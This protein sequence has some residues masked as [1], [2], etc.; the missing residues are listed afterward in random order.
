[1]AKAQDTTITTIDEAPKFIEPVVATELQANNDGDV[2]SGQ[3]VELTINQG[4]GDAGREPVF[5]G[6]NGTGYQIPRDIPVNVPVELL[7]IL[8]NA[9]QVIYE[10][11]G[12]T[13][14]GRLVKRF[15]YN[16]RAAA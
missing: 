13:S 10:A 14:R 4:E 5:V 6:L 12:A 11:N 7:H 2:L 1:M 9:V 16:T 3:R 8:D 15:S